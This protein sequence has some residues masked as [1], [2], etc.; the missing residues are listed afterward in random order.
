M[1]LN[2]SHKTYRIGGLAT[3]DCGCNE[4]SLGALPENLQNPL[5]PVGTLNSNFN[6]AISNKLWDTMKA[7]ARAPYPELPYAGAGVQNPWSTRGGPFTVTGLTVTSTPPAPL[8]VATSGG[9]AKG[10][11]TRAMNGL[12]SLGA[13]PALTAPFP[14]QIKNPFITGNNFWYTGQPTLNKNEPLYRNDAEEFLRSAVVDSDWDRVEAWLGWALRNGMTRDKLTQ[15]DFGRYKWTGTK[16]AKKFYPFSHA[17][18]RSFYERFLKFTAVT[19]PADRKCI[20]NKYEMA[21]KGANSSPRNQFIL[22]LSDCPLSESWE[23][24]L[25]KVV[26]SIAIPV[27]LVVTAGAIAGALTAGTAAGGAGVAT[28]VAAGETAGGVSAITGLTA[29]SA[30]IPAGIEGVVSIATALP[31]L[32]A[33]TI[34]TSVGAGLA[35]GAL[36]ASAPPPVVAQPPA[37]IAA[38]EISPVIETVVT[39]ST[40][41]PA[42]PTAGTIATTAGAGIASGA[43]VATSTPPAPVQT[44]QP[45]PVQDSDTIETVVTEGTRIPVTDPGLVSI[46]GPSIALDI[47]EIFSPEPPSPQYE[48][49]PTLGDQIKTGL[50]DA[51]AQYGQQ[52]VEDQLA[53]YL[54]DQLNH[55]PTQD[56]LDAWQD[57]I[58]DGG[59]RP[60]ANSST[61]L[62]PWLIVGGLA[63]AV[64]FTETKRGRTKHR[65]MR[66]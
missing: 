22:R 44:A 2:G 29:G 49:D 46:I 59:L 23:K 28:G 63:A 12:G 43:L 18:I 16:A 30:A 56:D 15:F 7:L 27:A 13:T 52:Y 35:S 26:A 37:P 48:D 61:T 3:G 64:V 41:L 33:G 65:R 9:R 21:L 14:Y 20:Q 54:Q 45:E 55:P 8:P 11:G 38:P 53:Q 42:V 58:D 34:A 40:F 36:I 5:Y 25:L 51:A 4:G 50:Q 62:W 60:S 47:P 19:M 57:W 17:D 1:R 10:V 32:G 39:E 66:S 24:G 31:V 6:Q